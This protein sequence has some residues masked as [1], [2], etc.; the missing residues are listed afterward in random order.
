[1]FQLR[2]HI[3]QARSLIGSDA[4]GLSDPF[5]SVI[6]GEFTKTTQVIDETLSPTWD[7]LLTFEEILIYGTS[8]EIQRDPPAIIIEI[9]DQDKVGKSEFIGR[10]VAKPHVKLREDSYVKP[11]FPPSLEWFDITRGIDRAGELL[12]AFEL[13]E[14]VSQSD[15]AELPELPLP[16]DIPVFKDTNA[17]DVGPILPVPR[18]IRPT[19]AR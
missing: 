11:R 9:F 15:G 18:G 16:K 19:L 1:M 5:A 12:A 4:S 8:E 3:Y 13:L 17:K 2:A 10:A 6:A 7:E 14:I